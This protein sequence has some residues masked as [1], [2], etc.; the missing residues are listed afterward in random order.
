MDTITNLAVQK[1]RDRSPSG[2]TVDRV[3][4]LVEILVAF[5]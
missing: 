1:S 3:A 5:G 4:A 2:N